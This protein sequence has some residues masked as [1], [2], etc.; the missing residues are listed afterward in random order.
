MSSS[1]LKIIQV[2]LALLIP[3]FLLGGSVRLVASE[4]FL[5][6]EYARSGFPPDPYGFSLSERLG[7]ARKNL[8]FVRLNLPITALSQQQ[9]DGLPVYNQRELSHMQDVQDVF[10]AAWRVWQISVG[11]ILLTGA[12]QWLAMRNAADVAASLQA[13]GLLTAGL[14][15]GIGVLAV[16][17]W[18][19]WF[20][21][22][23]QFFFQPD[24]W[25]FYYSDTLIRLFPVQFWYDITSA[26][27]VISLIGA[28]V[29][30]FLGWRWKVLLTKSKP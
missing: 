14:V 5:E 11:L 26:V 29:V 8:E 10:Q 16:F 23:H 6:I 25:L 28:I 30:A 1:L 17:S 9:I 20:E 21:L 15:I 27:I 22:F 3:V 18:Q 19:L 7:L 24:S 13:G 12:L 4:K 2:L